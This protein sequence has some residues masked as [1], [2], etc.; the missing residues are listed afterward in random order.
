M[1]GNYSVM[2]VVWVKLM[3]RRIIVTYVSGINFTVKESVLG[4]TDGGVGDA[5][6][7]VQASSLFWVFVLETRLYK[8]SLH[9]F[10]AR[11]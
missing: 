5:S 7:G 8:N 11:T 9:Y 4:F 10:P 2:A 3:H 1:F 6:T